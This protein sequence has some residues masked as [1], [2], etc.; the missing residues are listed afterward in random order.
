MDFF[1][2]SV[3]EKKAGVFEARPDFV[4]GR[5]EDL[6]VRQKGFYAVWDEDAGLWSTDIYDVQRIVDNK[7]R[8]YHDNNPTV[9]VK[10]VRDFSSNGM[11]TFNKYM[12]EIGDN[13]HPLDERL[14]FKSDVVTKKDYVSKRLPY[15]LIPGDHSAWDEMVG[16]LYIPAQREKIEWFIGAIVSGDSRKLHKFLVLEGPPGRGKGTVIDIVL[17]LFQGY[18]TT[19]NAKALASS[20]NQFA[21]AAFENNPLV[22]IQHDGDLSRVEDNTTINSIVSHEWMKINQKNKPAYD[23]KIIA[24]LIMG[25]NKPVQIT[26]AQSGLI[27]RLIDVHPSGNII[28][29]KHYHALK[30]RIAFEL[31]AIAHHCLQVYLTLGKNY[32]ADYKPTEMMFKTNAFFNFIEYHFDLFEKQDGA[33]ARQA[34]GLYKEYC[35]E[36]NLKQM[37]QYG[38]KAEF[39][40]YFNEYHDRYTLDGVQLRSYYKGFKAEKAE[41]FKQPTDADPKTFELRLDE[42]ISLLDLELANYAAQYANEQGH[43]EKRWDNVRTTLAE[44]D[45]SR[46]HFVQGFPETLIVADF[47]LT[48]ADGKKSRQRNLEAAAAWKPTYAEFS[49]SGDAIHLHYWYDGD[50]NELAAE[51][52]P[53]IEIKVFTGRMALRRRVSFCNA[54]PIAHLNSGLPFKEKKRVLDLQE[55]QSEKGLRRQIEKAL[56]KEIHS[57]TKSNVDYIKMILDEFYESG[58]DYDVSDLR[59]KITIFATTSSNQPIAALKTVSQMRWKSEEPKPDVSSEPSDPRLVFYDIEVFPNLFVLCW[60]FE[61]EE[62][63]AESVVRLVNPK[64]HEVEA[65]TRFKLVGQNV[66]DYDNHIIKA[67]I[68]G[69]TNDQLYRLSKRIIDNAPNAKFG[70]AYKISYTDTL[71]F[72]SE[73]LSLKKWQIRLG[74]DHRENDHPWDEPVPPEKV[75]EIVD[76]CVNDVVS[77]EFLFKH[78]EGDW[79]ARL[80]LA[81]LAGMTPNEK[82]STLTAKI[83]F[84]EAKNAR[85]QFVYTRLADMFPGYQYSF[86]K[87]TYRGV[88]VNEGGF[89][90]AEPGVYENV[91]LLDVASMHPTSIGQL[92][93]FGDEYTPRYMALVE[94]QLALKEVAQA[95]KDEDFDKAL[96]RIEHAKTLLDG[97]LIPYLEDIERLGK[98]DA[99]AA[100]KAAKQMRYGLKIAMNI[101]YGMTSAKFDNAFKDSRNVDNIVAKRGALFM[102]DL[103]LALRERGVTIAHIKT[104]SVKIP[105]ATSEDIQFVMDFGK[106]YGYT[107]EHEDTYEKFALFNDAVYI[108][109]KKNGEWTATGTQ[110]IKERNPYVYK[111]LLSLEDVDFTDLCVQKAVVKGDI[112]MDFGIH[113]EVE[114]D[115]VG[116]VESAQLDIKAA[117]KLIKQAGKSVNASDMFV[118][119]QAM[120]EAIRSYDEAIKKLIFVGKTGLFTPVLPGY[121]GGQ[122]W[123][124]QDG[125]AYAVNG[126]KGYLW[127]DSSTVGMNLPD[128]AIDYSYFDKLVDEARVDIEKL[129]PGTRFETVE[130]FLA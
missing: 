23:A 10:Y 108:A 42:T 36:M 52:A 61:E 109:K 5:S 37:P 33:T 72:A 93:L 32:Y 7:L 46:E 84:G 85:S 76:Y 83:I 120:E 128:E 47:D 21:S 55:I 19:F 94:G 54:L 115:L 11:T 129:L 3:Q 104:D 39:G 73:K 49:R 100:G 116:Y 69:Y 103:L 118:A 59:Q 38:F 78:L 74:L 97:K 130:D 117:E 26:D 62:P 71:D 126:T 82:T 119:N 43:P 60:K 98:V 35:E 63:K 58:R 111:K 80:L 87:S 18:T 27:R 110:F 75:Q 101:V 57:G 107:F 105:N 8:A 77:T 29:P 70:D 66:R 99:Q 114:N 16:T 92:N 91:A 95:Y 51:Y 89:V 4:V 68:L 20:A 28:P 1:K 41:P 102:V 40:H 79:K 9:N 15:D 53:G 125:R 123:R 2:I 17:D 50:V 65:L 96:N 67:A 86:G 24:A 34:F 30:A 81:E 44:I 64:P 13:H 121:G 88:D 56:N 31:G 113:D 90:Y 122:L 106:R 12:R 124:V 22:A 6:M 45:T 25:T 127:V 48:D 14:T 112:R